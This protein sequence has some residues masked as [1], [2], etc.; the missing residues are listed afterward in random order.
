MAQRHHRVKT[1]GPVKV[2]AEKPD[3]AFEYAPRHTT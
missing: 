3:L 1:F 2:E